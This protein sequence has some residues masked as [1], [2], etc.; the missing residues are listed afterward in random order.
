MVHPQTQSGHRVQSEIR[1][2][3]LTLIQSDLGRRVGIGDTRI[4]GRRKRDI[5][6]RFL[7]EIRIAPGIA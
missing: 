2:E 1:G 7:G 3:V 4:E 6:F 5:E